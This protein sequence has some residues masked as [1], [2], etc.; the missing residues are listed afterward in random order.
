MGACVSPALGDTFCGPAE[1][2]GAPGCSFRACPTG[3]R[4]DI[5]SGRCDGTPPLDFGLC[6]QHEL[7][8][9]EN[10]QVSCVPPDATCPRLKRR[11]G[12][13]CESAPSCPPGSLPDQASCRPIVTV[14]HRGASRVEVGLWAALALGMDGGLGSAALCQPLSQRPT[15]FGVAPKG[16]LR[17]DI[18]VSITMPDQDVSAVSARVEATDSRGLPLSPSA[19]AVV[20][21]AATTLVELLRSLGGES[22]TAAVGVHVRCDLGAR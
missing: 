2:A 12:G 6:S 18:R 7:S 17:I 4:L 13:T 5:A 22:R 8:L 21:D 1:S 20:T 11:V 15:V 9:L 14:G 3:E 16:P 10:E 19:E